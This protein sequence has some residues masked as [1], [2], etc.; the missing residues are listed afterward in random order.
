[1]Y[2]LQHA[3]SGTGTRRFSG[4]KVINGQRPQWQDQVGR[5]VAL[6]LD[7]R[8]FSGAFHLSCLSRTHFPAAAQQM[9]SN[10][11]ASQ[12]VILQTY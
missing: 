6:R 2:V 4:Q 10:A 11:T 3:S 7:S 8:L 12:P 1:M 9:I 5:V